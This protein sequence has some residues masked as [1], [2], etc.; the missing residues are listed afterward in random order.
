M[1]LLKST[2]FRFF[3]VAAFLVLF[4]WLSIKGVD[5]ERFL[6]ALSN[7]DVRLWL[8]ALPIYMSSHVI[9]AFRWKVLLNSFEVFPVKRLFGY[10]LSGLALNN[11]IPARLGEFLR[12]YLVKGKTL[13]YST[14]LSV[15]AVERVLDGLVLATILAATM[16]AFRIESSWLQHVRTVA[17]TG[18]GLAA[19]AVLAVIFFPRLLALPKKLLRVLPEALAEKIGGVI[20]HVA[21]GL[22]TIGKTR[23]IGVALLVTYLH[24]TVEAVFYLL[25]FYSF[26]F[27]AEYSWALL[28]VTLVSFGTIIPATPGYLGVFQFACIMALSMFGVAKSEAFAVSIV[29]HIT[30]YVLTTGL[31]LLVISMIGIS[32]SDAVGRA[33]SHALN[34]D[35]S[36]ERMS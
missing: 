30:Q 16:G 32:L 29:I 12:A 25:V 10:I 21:D 26:G 27:P 9:R 15:I 4:S 8:A 7:I 24:W 34:H 19:L 33:R 31:G 20:D 1:A 17:L 36:N 35:A 14:S 6:A 18:F 3:V 5:Y 11:I 28:T 23:I 13:P 22:Q 2:W